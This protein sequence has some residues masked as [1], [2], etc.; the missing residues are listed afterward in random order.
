MFGKGNDGFVGDV[1]AFVE[2]E[3]DRMLTRF[4][5]RIWYG[6]MGITH[7]FEVLAGSREVYQ[8]IVSYPAAACN[9]KAL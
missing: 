4:S 3:L 2:F 9:I 1:A 6:G 8:R 7:S 5:R